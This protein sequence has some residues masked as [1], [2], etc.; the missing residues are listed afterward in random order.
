MEG[1]IRDGQIDMQAT[2]PLKPH[3]SMCLRILAFSSPACG[4]CCVYVSPTYFSIAS[5]GL[6]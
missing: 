1:I 2:H 4:L 3:S 5:F 6:H